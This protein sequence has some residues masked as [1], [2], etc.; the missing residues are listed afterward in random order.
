MPAQRA[1]LPPERGTGGKKPYGVRLSA[2]GTDQAKRASRYEQPLVVPQLGHAW[3][4]PARCICT[5]HW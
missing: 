2:S 5:P 4:E 3:H 1:D